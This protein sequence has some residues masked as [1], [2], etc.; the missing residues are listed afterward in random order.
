MKNKQVSKKADKLK[1]RKQRYFSEAF[2]RS[3]VEEL[4]QKQV[5]ISEICK[6]YGVNSSTVYRWL[7]KYSP[8]HS[9]GTKQVVEMESEAAKTFALRQRVSELEQVI[10]RKQLTIDFL[11]KLIEIA[12]QEVGYDIKK[13]HGQ[14]QSSGLDTT[15]SSTHTS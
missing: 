13:N 15:G 6:L 5:S 2:K 7:Y 12:S 8:H 11:E 9:Q 4:A 14:K 1:I 10:G 3:K